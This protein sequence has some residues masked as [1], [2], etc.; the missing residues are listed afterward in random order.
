MEILEEK[1]KEGKV[2]IKVETLDDLW[3]LYHI[4][5]P[6]DVVYAKTLRKQSQRSDS[7]RPEK[8]EVIPVFLGVKVEKINFHK[9][10]N[11]LR[12][13]GPIIY[14][15]REDV[16][17]GKYHTIAVE[18][19]TIITLQKERWKPYYIER[20]KEAVEASKRAKVMIVTIEDG[21]AEMAI[22][23]EY[24]LDF[25]A[26]IRHNLGGKRYNIKRED[27]ERKFSM[28]SQRQ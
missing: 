12:V 19:G 21:E 15:S 6:G 18:P 13:T 16:P 28:M 24:G 23:R 14:A 26:T 3:H 8:V 10:A 25:I 7:L 20:L 17:L 2:K 11:Q 27:E 9:F 1:P 4:I 5:T 22:V